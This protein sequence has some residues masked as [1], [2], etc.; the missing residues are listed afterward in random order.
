LRQHKFEAYLN[1]VFDVAAKVDTLPEGH[2]SPRHDGKRFFEA[3]FLGA[4]CQFASF[5][6]CTGSK[7]NAREVRLIAAE[8]HALP[9]LCLSTV[10]R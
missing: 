8:F 4:A 10:P 9:R 6:P 5:P 7:H 2:Q 1:K 3:V